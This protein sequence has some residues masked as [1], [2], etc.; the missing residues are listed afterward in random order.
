M[1]RRQGIRSPF[2][3]TRRPA[4]ARPHSLGPGAGRRRSGAAAR[5]TG[6]DGDGWAGRTP[7]RGL[8]QR[9]RHG[10]GAFPARRP[11]QRGRGGRGGRARR[12]LSKAPVVS[13][14]LRPG[15]ASMPAVGVH[16]VAAR[17]AA[18]RVEA[19]LAAAARACDRLPPRPSATG[20][21]PVVLDL[22]AVE[23]GR[24]AWPGRRLAQRSSAGT[25]SCRAGGCSATTSTCCTSGPTGCGRPEIPGEPGMAGQPGNPGI[26]ISAPPAS[27]ARMRSM[28][29]CGWSRAVRRVATTLN[30]PAL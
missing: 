5:P 16:P 20:L 29:H 17:G 4:T 11:P 24:W 10:T 25:T 21:N 12:Q 3:W 19:A 6:T 2:A 14:Q 18:A 27:P 30:A 1:G 13:P 26:G 23:P 15:R 28:R 7:R 8:A 9:E 22:K